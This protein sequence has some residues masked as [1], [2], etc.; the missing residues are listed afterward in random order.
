MQLIEVGPEIANPD[1]QQ[2]ALWKHP[3]RLSTKTLRN[4]RWRVSPRRDSGGEPMLFELV[5][6]CRCWWE[7][8]CG[9]SYFVAK[10]L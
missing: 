1:M 6:S 5:G 7:K 2:N 9:Y 8:V 3:V 4:T 10:A